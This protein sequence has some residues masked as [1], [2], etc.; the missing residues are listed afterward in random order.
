MCDGDFETG[1]RGCCVLGRV[2]PAHLRRQLVNVKGKRSV[3]VCN[4]VVAVGGP[5]V[6]DHLVR[7]RGPPGDCRG[8]CRNIPSRCGVR[9]PRLGADRQLTDAKISA[10]QLTGAQT[11]KLRGRPTRLPRAGR[12]IGDLEA[13]PQCFGIDLRHMRARRQALEVIASVLV[14]DDVATILKVDSHAAHALTFCNGVLAFGNDHAAEQ[15]GRLGKEIVGHADADLGRVGLHAVRCLGARD[16]DNFA[17][18]RQRA[19][20]DH[21]A[22]AR[23]A[24]GK[25]VSRLNC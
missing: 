12:A 7:L 19:N 8:G 21:V 9:Q 17:D 16:V 20:F 3:F 25:Q 10:P 13:R 6:R 11:H 22:N 4:S 18:A 15:R 23:A 5:R 2:N 1:Y 24:S 14:R